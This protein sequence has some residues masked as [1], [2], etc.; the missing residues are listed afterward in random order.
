MPFAVPKEGPIEAWQ[1][2]RHLFF[3]A[4]LR[5]IQGDFE[6]AIDLYQLSINTYPTAEA[7]TFLGWMYSWMGRYGDAIHEAK[8]AIALDPDYGNPYN[9][10]GA[11]L[12]EQGKL[13]EAIPWLMQAMQ[14][15]R[16]T[17]PHY[18]WL[19]LGNIL[20][21][22]GQWGKALSSYEE[23][24]K[25]AP[26]YPVPIVLALEAALFLPTK[27]DRDPGATAEQQAV[28]EVITRYF[29]AWN[30]YDADT[31]K[32]YSDP[33]STEASKSLLLRLA[34]AKLAGF[35]VAVDNSRVLHMEGSMAIA[36][37]SVSVFGKPDIIWHL[38][39]QTKDS[40]KVVVRLST[41]LGSY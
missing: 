34:A 14:A 31:L 15:K 1:E 23:V 8:H 16:Y 27:H 20:V 40:W 6:E 4:Y 5:Q 37:T 10:I 30:N 35:T 2:A 22:K 9:D 36:E 12:I 41:K 3:T 33:L 32:E 38:L 13:D 39:R 28:K 19:N 18:P 7:Y 29:Q 26:E 21:L 24:F 17:S 11:Y 25:L